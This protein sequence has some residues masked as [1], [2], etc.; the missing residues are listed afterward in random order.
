MPL[1]SINF[2]MFLFCSKRYLSEIYTYDAIMLVIKDLANTNYIY[3]EK[4]R[5]AHLL[6]VDLRELFSSNCIPSFF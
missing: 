5:Q 2:F 1:S 3:N 4:H 6:K